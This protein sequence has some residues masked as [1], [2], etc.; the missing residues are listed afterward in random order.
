[1]HPRRLAIVRQ[2]AWMGLFV[3][4]MGFAGWSSVYI[5]PD[6]PGAAPEAIRFIGV[7]FSPW[8]VGECREFEQAVG[9]ECRQSAYSVRWMSWS[10]L[11][12]PIGLAS[13]WWLLR[14]PANATRRGDSPGTAG[15]HP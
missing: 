8:L 10:W 3:F 1:M 15:S 11:L 4:V 2:F 13:A 14:R 7:P 12:L 6:H 5:G 9:I